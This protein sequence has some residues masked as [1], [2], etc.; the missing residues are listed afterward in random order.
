MSTKYRKRLISAE[1][2]AL[3]AVG[4]LSHLPPAAFP[5]RFRDA[6]AGLGAVFDPAGTMKHIR[7]QIGQHTG[8]DNVYFVASGRLAL[9]LIL[10]SMKDQKVARKVILPAYGCSTILQAVLEAGLEPEFCDVSPDTLDYDPAV[11]EEKLGPDVLAVVGVQ[12]YGLGHDYAG[13]V[14]VAREAGVFFIEDAA[15]SF[16]SFVKGKPVGMQGDVGFYSL[17]RGKCLPASGGG[18]IV[19]Q[20]GKGKILEVILGQ[21]ALEPSLGVLHIPKILGYILAVNPVGWWFV[22][23]S[24]FNPARAGKDL[25]QL[26]EIQTRPFSAVQGGLA[27]SLL[28]RAETVYRTW[29][30]NAER[31]VQSLSHIRYL[32]I[33]GLEE[34]SAP[35]FLRFPVLIDT[36][37]RTER[38]FAKLSAAGIGVSHSYR[39]TL[40]GL[41][42]EETGRETGTFPGAN[43]LAAC[44]LTLPTHTYLTE[45]SI[46][47]VERIFYSERDPLKGY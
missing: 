4:F 18:V 45:S 43:H 30:E 15:Q 37:E 46:H 1:R 8:A 3:Q 38:L 28:E 13:L 12:L 21:D 33:P 47:A 36:P 9:K 10:V 24:P 11:A 25:A 2:G 34:G 31:L 41:Y 39:F 29:K 16:G 40:P 44:L 19:A 23:R 17:G 20:N 32:H 26:P 6:V 35:V 14:Q 27:V 22:S 42:R 5:V 7:E